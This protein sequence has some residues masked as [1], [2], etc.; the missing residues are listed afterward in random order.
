MKVT[1]RPTDKRVIALRITAPE[2]Q[3]DPKSGKKIPLLS[4]IDS[5]SYHK[6]YPTTKEIF[7][8]AA[9]NREEGEVPD[10]LDRLLH[11]EFVVHLNKDSKVVGIDVIPSR[12]YRS[13]VKPTSQDGV[14]TLTIQYLL[15]GAVARV[16]KRP[17]NTRFAQS[18]AVIKELD[19]MITRGDTIEVSTRVGDLGRV[20]GVTETSVEIK[21]SAAANKPER[22][23]GDV[24]A[25]DLEDVEA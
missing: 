17:F 23:R 20:V 13:G 16:M 8:Y 3:I 4:F 15:G 10:G 22:Q 21:L 19:D 25:D 18:A 14:T 2:T 12:L 5:A 6:H 1:P 11:H 9:G 24:T 7:L